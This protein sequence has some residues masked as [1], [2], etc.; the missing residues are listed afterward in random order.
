MITN[1]W[2]LKLSSEMNETYFKQMF[3][4]LKQE[5]KTKN[6]YPPKKDIF[7]ALKMT[8][9]DNVKVVILG[10]DPYHGANEAHGYA[11]SV[12]EGVKTPP[13][14]RNIFIEL[15]NDLGII[16]DTTNLE[17]WA[18]QGVL[19]L[20]TILTVE[21]NKPLSHKNIGWEIFS[22]K[23]ISLLNEN[24]KPIVFILW[25]THARSKQYLVTNNKHLIIES[26][27]PSPLSAHS[28]FFGSKPFS[29]T[30]KFLKENNI[31]EIQW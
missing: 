14:L 5:Y 28:G 23:I 11:F 22:N 19:L 30:N 16:K 18:K 25:G 8:D 2:D 29:K 13:S 12:Q 20:N 26:V 4:Y 31:E 17:K 10:Q 3:L 21:E 15:E 27:H 24:D 1:K 7:N 6:I 9:F